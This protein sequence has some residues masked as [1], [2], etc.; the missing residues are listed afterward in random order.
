MSSH[1]R[2]VTVP[3]VPLAEFDWSFARSGP[4]PWNQTVWS[5]IAVFTAL[6]IW[7]TFEL[8]LW[9]F[10]SFR[11]YRGLYFWSVLACT[12]GTTIHA[13]GFVLKIC[14]PQ[15]NWILAT[16]LAEIGWVGMVTGFSVVLYSRL[17][18]LLAGGVHKRTWM[19][20]TLAMIVTDA[21]LFHVPTIVF[22]F[23][24]SSAPTHDKYLPFM[25]PMERVQVMAFS[26]QE[27]LISAM[28]IYHTRKYLRNSF[29]KDTRKTIA[30]LIWVQVIVILCDV[31]V[32][33]LDYLEYFSLKA[34]LHSFV[35]AFKLQLEFVIL[36]DIKAMAQKGS[37][38][39]RSPN[40]GQVCALESDGGSPKSSAV[41]SGKRNWRSFG[42]NLHSQKG[43][44]EI[45]L[46]T[47]VR[48]HGSMGS[49]TSG[50]GS[51]AHVKADSH[52]VANNGFITTHPITET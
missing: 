41:F 19:N 11:R 37:L 4:L 25:A 5:I 6:P 45:Q 49:I 9:I 52:K 43:P 39:L 13:L 22:Q 21:F 48:Y 28:Y 38:A 16:V 36:N 51:A 2:N 10:Y 15:C 47:G 34:V 27:T 7:M 30:L 18:L 32:I 3:W 44:Q 24:V 23:G 46:G 26:V 29:Q 8:T 35:Y 20:L 14:V 12:W 33:T 31:L 42:L 17:G 40:S 50:D 1:V